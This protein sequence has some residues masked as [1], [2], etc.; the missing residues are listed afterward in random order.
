M[1]Q[2]NHKLKNKMFL[3]CRVERTGDS[4]Q[5]TAQPRAKLACLSPETNSGIRGDIDWK[6]TWNPFSMGKQDELQTL[7]EESELFR[8]PE[9]TSVLNWRDLK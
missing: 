6:S 9:M 3:L 1:A 8:C 7:M 4:I 5:K 2:G